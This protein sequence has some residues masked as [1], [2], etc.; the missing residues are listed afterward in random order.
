M[1]ALLARA[2][3]YSLFITSVGGHRERRLYIER[4]LRPR[5][6]DRLLDIGCGPADIL[7][8]LPDVEY[9]GFDLSADYIEAAR[10]K[11]GSRGHFHV[12][13]VN[14][15]LVKKYA[16]FDLVLA[17][18]VIHHLNDAEALDLLEVAKMALKPGG[19]LVTLDPCWAK[20]QSPIARFMLK[21]DRGKHI[22]DQPSYVALARQVFGKVDSIIATDLLYMPYTHHVMEC[23]APAP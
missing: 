14:R 9:H 8:V 23:H 18:G 20:G 16:G 10:K 22:R 15:E 17:I 21:Q 19:R 2:G 3:I 13:A 1:K 4:Y 5:V 7:D 12:E 6:G 11:Y